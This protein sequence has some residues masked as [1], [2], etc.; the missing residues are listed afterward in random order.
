VVLG[1]D[2]LLHEGLWAT[3]RADG[4]GRLDFAPAL[5]GVRSVVQSAELAICHLETSLAPVG[6]PYSGNPMFS[7]PPQIARALQQS[8]FDACTTAS[9]HSLDRGPDGVRRTLDVLDR[10]DLQHAG[11]ARTAAEGRR[12]VLL[13][14]GGV[15]VGLVSQTYG[16]SGMPVTEPWSVQL[17]DESD[18]TKRVAEARRAGAQIVLVALHWGAEYQREPTPE[19]RALARRLLR[20]PDIDLIYGHHAHVVQPFERV[21]RR[22]VAYGLGNMMAQQSAMQTGTY[23][24]VLAQFTFLERPDGGFA[25]E[26]A[27]YVPTF[28]TPFDPGD[29]DMRLL[30]IMDV[31][32]RAAPDAP[33][34]ALR[35]ALRRTDEAVDLL[36]ATADGLTRQR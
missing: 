8:G 5:A 3:A 23:E 1:G 22:W 35:A 20:S 36:G 4:R 10:T 12:P 25:A 30:S 6:G 28:I 21:R 32:P 19:Q 16:T 14:A 27:Q 17:I 15:T 34:V 31:L 24:G 18:I 13:D 33:R 7:A 26:D 29:P 2:I 11:T 9:N